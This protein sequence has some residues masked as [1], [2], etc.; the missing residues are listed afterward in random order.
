[1]AGVAL[2]GSG[3]SSSHA[4][5]LPFTEDFGSTLDNW[6]FVDEADLASSWAIVNGELHQQ[7]RVESAS[8]FDQSYHLGTKKRNRNP[9]GFLNLPSSHF[10]YYPANSP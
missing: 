5:S 1:L 9:E 10:L 3:S 2:A 8:A 6:V 7:N 4:L